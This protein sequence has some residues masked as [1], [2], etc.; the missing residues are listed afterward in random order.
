MG[1]VE[2]AQIVHVY[3]CNILLTEL[4]LIMQVG[5]SVRY[6]GCAAVVCEVYSNAVMIVRDSGACFTVMLDDA[7]LDSTDEPDYAMRP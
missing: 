3:R 4:E 7:G 6:A 5:Q 1:N 2:L